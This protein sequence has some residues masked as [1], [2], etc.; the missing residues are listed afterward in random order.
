MIKQTKTGL[1]CDCGGT[2][3]TKAI[4][5]TKEGTPSKEIVNMK[6]TGCEQTINIKD[7]RAKKNEQ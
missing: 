3:F 1:L 2:N 4:P 7:L 5:T 6:C